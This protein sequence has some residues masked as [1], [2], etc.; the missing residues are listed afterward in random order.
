MRISKLFV[1]VSMSSIIYEVK[2]LIYCRAQFQAPR[3]NFK[4]VCNHP[5]R[6]HEATFT[7]IILHLGEISMITLYVINTE[8]LCTKNNV[9]VSV[10]LSETCVVIISETRLHYIV[11]LFIFYFSVQM[12]S[13]QISVKSSLQCTVIH[14]LLLFCLLLQVSDSI[15]IRNCQALAP[16]PKPQTQNQGA[17]G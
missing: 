1:Y 9:H 5:L 17:L 10:I 2:R 16:N 8:P 12:Y 3:S 15:K 14:C 7:V 13:L 11:F 6:S 4:L